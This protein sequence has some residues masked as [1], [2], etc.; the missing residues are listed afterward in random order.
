MTSWLRTLIPFKK[1][2]GE[3]FDDADGYYSLNLTS[4]YSIS[5]NLSV[6]LKVTNLFD[7]KYGTVNATI[8][9]ENLVYN[10]QLR[11][12]LRFGLSYRLN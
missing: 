3:L 9:E 6:F 12:S 10:P 4:N 2:Y 5:D 1:L 8:L 11:R 7:E